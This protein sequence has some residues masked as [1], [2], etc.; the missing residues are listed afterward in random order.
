MHEAI[1]RARSPIRT[2]RLRRPAS[3]R[4]LLP[5]SSLLDMVEALIH[6]PE[7][8][9]L[10]VVDDEGRLQGIVELEAVQAAIN[11]RYGVRGSGLLG[12]TRHVRD[13][14]RETAAQL[15]RPAPAVRDDASIR[16]A[17][18]LAQDF[19]LDAIPVTDRN[20]RLVSELTAVEYLEL[21]LDVAMESRPT[22]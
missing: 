19:S 20:G 13:L 6:H 2:L 17:L 9:A 1:P 12:F 22:P 11:A 7:H 3:A 14:Q 15:M 8:R 4:I 18:R 10:Y 21:A 16:S 5:D